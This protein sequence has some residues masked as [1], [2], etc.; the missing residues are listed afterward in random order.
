MGGAI[1]FVTSL[2]SK[3][4]A[5]L[6]VFIE[7][8]KDGRLGADGF[9]DEVQAKID[10]ARERTSIR[11]KGG[12]TYA[13]RPANYQAIGEAGL[14]LQIASLSIAKSDYAKDA[15]DHL[16]TIVNEGIKIKE[17]PGGGSIVGKAADIAATVIRG[18]APKAIWN[19][20]T[21]NVEPA[22]AYDVDAAIRRIRGGR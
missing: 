20:V 5:T 15:A 14:K 8:L 18:D 21:S 11:A 13:A 16:Q 7:R 17:L 3:L 9:F 10:H 2:L 4:I 19:H 22:K 12:Q 1:K 6:A